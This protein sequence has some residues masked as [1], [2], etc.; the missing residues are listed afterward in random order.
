MTAVLIAANLNPL[1]AFKIQADPKPLFPA[2]AGT[3]AE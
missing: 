3:Q 1:R 2:K